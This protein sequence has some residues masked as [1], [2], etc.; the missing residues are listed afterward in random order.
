MANSITDLIVQGLQDPA[1]KGRLVADFAKVAGEEGVTLTPAQASAF[2][3]MTA[4][5]WR[6]VETFLT[7]TVESSPCTF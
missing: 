1:F 4:D 3:K 5:D 2:G 7:A 6:R